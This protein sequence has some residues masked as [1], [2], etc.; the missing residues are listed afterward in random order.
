MQALSGNL[1]QNIIL[2]V[3]LPF[4]KYFKFT[5]IISAALKGLK[6]GSGGNEL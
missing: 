6:K 3:F 2:Y 4:S 5:I 1:R